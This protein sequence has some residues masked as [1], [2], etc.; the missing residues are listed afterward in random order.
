[1]I[2]IK[3]TIIYYT[4]TDKIGKRNV[5]LFKHIY[6]YRINRTIASQREY[7]ARCGASPAIKLT[8][9]STQCQAFN[10]VGVRKVIMS[11]GC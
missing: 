4:K 6:I 10:N 5:F 2:K 1:M 8:I 9:M 7:D 11:L 3:S